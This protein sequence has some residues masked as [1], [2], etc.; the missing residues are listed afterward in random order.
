MLGAGL[1]NA[2]DEFGIAGRQPVLAVTDIVFEARAAMAASGET[3]LVDFPLVAPDT[4][5]N[6]GGLG[7][8]HGEFRTQEIENAA[9]CRHGIADAEH[10]LHM[11]TVA[12][13]AL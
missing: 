6:P 10:E 12:E 9:P 13:Q 8:H 2:A 1:H 7:Q 11:R 4:S 5:G 3:P